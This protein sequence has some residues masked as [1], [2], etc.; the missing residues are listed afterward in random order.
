M[1]WTVQR[2]SVAALLA[3]ITCVVSGCPQPVASPELREDFEYRV[4][5]AVNAARKKAGL[6][7]LELRADL[8][9]VA[10]DHNRQ[11]IS[12]ELAG[13]DN[14]FSHRDGVGLMVEGRLEQYHKKRIRRRAIDWVDAGENLARN[15]EFE[16]PVAEAVRGWLA[17]PEHRKNVLS[18]RF[19]ETGVAVHL[20]PKSKCYYFTQVFLLRM[21]P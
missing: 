17:S 11:M 9:T 18:K 5:H 8:R 16:D 7:L 21:L 19:R 4:F 10:R 12:R 20:S 13:D 3:G 6:P 14:A 15:R 1:T 2:I